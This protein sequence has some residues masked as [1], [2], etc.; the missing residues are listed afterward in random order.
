M[1][2]FAS[3]NGDYNRVKIHA[4]GKINLSLEILARRSDDF[5]EIKTVNQRIDLSDV[6]EIE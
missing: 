1:G 2:E 4:P 6:I 3:D 5:H